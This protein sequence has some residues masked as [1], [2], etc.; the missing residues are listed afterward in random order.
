MGWSVFYDSNCKVQAAQP[1]EAD[2][3][4]LQSDWGH[5]GIALTREANI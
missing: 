5:A 3:E 2:D 1:C 4:F